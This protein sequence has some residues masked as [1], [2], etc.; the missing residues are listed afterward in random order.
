MRS[1]FATPIIG[2]EKLHWNTPTSADVHLYADPATFK[3]D[4]PL[5]YADCEGLEAGASIPRAMPKSQ[6][7]RVAIAGGTMRK[8]K[9]AKIRDPLDP[10]QLRLP[11]RQYAVGKLYPRILYAFSD[12]VVF[13]IRNVRCVVLMD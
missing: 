2:S 10:S 4:R 1:S 13:V 9:W 6:P 3:K 8:L 11:S 7:R 12:V 5:L